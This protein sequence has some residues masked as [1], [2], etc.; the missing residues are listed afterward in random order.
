MLD[1]V[2]TMSNRCMLEAFAALWLICAAVP[3]HA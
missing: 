2:A 1:D 3:A